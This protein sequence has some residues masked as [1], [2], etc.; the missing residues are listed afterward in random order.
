MPYKL[1][2]FE[3][4]GCGQP[5]ER[6]GPPDQVTRCITCAIQRSTDNIVQL[7][8]KSGP[9]YQRWMQGITAGVAREQQLAAIAAEIDDIGIGDAR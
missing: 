4:A 8:R 9:L 2:T 1:R 6:R 5:V 3:C 7:R